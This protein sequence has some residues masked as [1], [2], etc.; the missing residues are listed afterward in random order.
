MKKFLI[1][2][3][4]IFILN[5]TFIVLLNYIG[6]ITINAESNSIETYTAKTIDSKSLEQLDYKQLATLLDNYENRIEQLEN[7]THNNSEVFAIYKDYVTNLLLILGAFVSL[8]SA[9]IIFAASLTIESKT[10]KSIKEF[11]TTESI[12]K[13][14]DPVVDSFLDE[15]KK[16]F[17]NAINNFNEDSSKLIIMFK[18]WSDRH[19]IEK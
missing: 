9:V 15:E 18:N 12:S 11:V 13:I 7:K 3:G 19:G 8:F 2:L 10:Q 5:I 14:I 6:V 17:S 16:K 1:L 4:L